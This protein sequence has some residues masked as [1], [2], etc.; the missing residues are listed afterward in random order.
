MKTLTQIFF[1]LT[2]LTVIVPLGLYSDTGET[3][4]TFLNL[5]VG[6]KSIALG[7]AV[8]SS[9]HGVHSLFWN[10][11]GLGWLKGTEAFVMHAE[12]F[13][14]IRYENV[15]LA[16]GTDAFG[17]GLSLKGLFLGGIEERT[18]PS[19]NPLSL[20]SASYFAPSLSFAKSISSLFSLGM[21]LK[22]V[23]Q[24]IG[25]DNASSF[26]M[27]AGV[28]MKT[29]LK[30][31]QLGTALS[32][33]GTKAQF[34]NEAYPLPSLIRTGISYSPL[35]NR[36]LFGID[37][38]KPFHEEIEY[39]IGVEGT[40]MDRFSLRTGYR[41]GL[42][43]TGD[44][45][46]LS[47]GAGFKVKDIDI[48]YAFTSYGV[49]GPSHTFSLSY[50]FGRSSG[51][52][53]REDERIAAE[54]LKRARLTAQAFY[55]QGISQ[56]NAG[57]FENAIKNFDIA[58][59]WDPTYEDAE[60]HV[61]DLRKKILKRESNE[62]IAQGIVFFNNGKYIEAVSEFGLVLEIEPNNE[63]AKE[64]LNTASEALVKAQMEKIRLE[65]EE[66]EKIESHFKK[67][68]N[69]F[70]KRNYTKAIQEW[71]LVLSL[72]PTYT[73][74]GIYISKARAEIKNQ[75]VESL[76][77]VD[78]YISNKKW[79]Q[80]YKEITFVLSLDP[81]NK[82]ALKRRSTIKE[83]LTEL[84]KSHTKT[85]IS[86]YKKKKYNAAETE[87]KLALELNSNN[88]T[89]QDYLNKIASITKK[90][91]SPEMINSLYLKGV[92]AYTK[93][94]F[95]LAISYWERVLELDPHH[96]N[97]TRNIKRAREKLKISK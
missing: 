88:K 70:S 57:E 30:G 65:Q 77:I 22:F 83:N 2:I 3:S 50:I 12:H 43:N 68:L 91:A 79:F 76:S 93:E 49:L 48:D 81:Q 67:G 86:L 39:R 42:Q 84:S 15:G 78:S 38:V 52:D 14:S 71:N 40:I 61:E 87:F 73:E 28:S 20:M 44:L 1:S 63:L 27:D 51:E 53:V 10:P 36:L 29:G 74:A 46:G 16:H 37:V 69:Y 41:S 55:Q 21:N 75:I 17:V 47:A 56:E 64:W 23:Y 80:A 95:K 18:G 24:K 58:L 54:L 34:I 66:K 8:T 96:T 33:I 82:E 45:A 89:A 9:A 90:K 35:D 94:D 5:G 13:Q 4:A 32:N 31:F 19:E 97:A 62:H 92:D 6:A 72:D 25:E 7:G 11:G 60:R 59:I 85:G 26:A